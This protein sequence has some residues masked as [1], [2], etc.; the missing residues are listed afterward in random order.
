[1]DPW[2]RENGTRV[3]GRVLGTS[4]WDLESSSRIWKF[5]TVIFEDSS[6]SSKAWGSIRGQESLT[7]K[8]SRISL[9]GSSTRRCS[10]GL[11]DLSESRVL[12]VEKLKF[13]SRV[14]G[15]EGAA[16]WLYKLSSSIFGCNFPHPFNLSCVGIP[17]SQ[18]REVFPPGFG[19]CMWW[20]LAWN[21]PQDLLD[22]F[23]SF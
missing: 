18:L 11:K 23:L 12:Q 15:L 17:F 2:T 20:S 7:V 19:Q 10:R 6:W 16:K 5:P 8:K 4:P 14:R 13:I 21:Q 3:C 22:G 1:M 9:S